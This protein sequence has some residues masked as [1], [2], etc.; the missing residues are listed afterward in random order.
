MISYNID[1]T[2]NNI[3]IIKC[4]TTI[5]YFIELN[6]NMKLKIYYKILKIN[7]CFVCLNN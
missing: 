7:I 1:E 5:I 6:D 3:R 4:S 2:I